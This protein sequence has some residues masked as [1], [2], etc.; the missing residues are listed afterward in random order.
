MKNEID[1]KDREAL[2]ILAEECAEVVQ[3][4]SKIMRFG[5]NNTWNGKTARQ[6]LEMELGDVRAMIDILLEREVIREN[7]LQDAELNKIAKL[8]KWS[9]LFD[10]EQP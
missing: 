2:L 10:E 6:D 1:P 3:A 9:H 8:H 7:K 4:V 5:I